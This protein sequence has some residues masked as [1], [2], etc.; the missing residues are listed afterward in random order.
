MY[1]PAPAAM[2]TADVAHR[3]AAVV[4]PRITM[5]SLRI[6][7]APRKP[8]PDTIWAAI[9]V[10]SIGAPVRARAEAVG[11][12]DR[13]QRRPDGDEHVRPQPGGMAVDLALE[14]DGETERR[15][16]REPD[17]EVEL[18]GEIDH[19]RQA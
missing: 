19:A 3:L 15:R 12:Q 14:S 6:A 13:E 4:R 1:S 17:R 9:R 8:M 7:P 5:P 16:Q 2:P 10:G 11:R 18:E